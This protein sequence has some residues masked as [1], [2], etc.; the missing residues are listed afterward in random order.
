M[1]V[2]IHTT[3]IDDAGAKSSWVYFDGFRKIKAIEL[4]KFDGI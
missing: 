1:I 2:K 3:Q 4:K